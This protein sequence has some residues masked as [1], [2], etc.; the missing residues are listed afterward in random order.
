MR[1]A[2]SLVDVDDVEE[3]YHEIVDWL[4]MPADELQDRAAMIA[5][6][7][8]AAKMALRAHS[9]Y[10]KVRRVCASERRKLQRGVRDIKRTATKRLKEWQRDEGTGKAISDSM[11]NEEI[12]GSPSLSERWDKIMDGVEE[13]DGVVEAFEELWRRARGRESLLQSQSRIA[14]PDKMVNIQT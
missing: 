9:L 3:R 4:E 6:I 1:K 14:F 5:R 7:N 2:A 10:L 13:V 8:Q 11:I 12:L